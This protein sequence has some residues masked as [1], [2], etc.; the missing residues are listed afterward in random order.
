MNRRLYIYQRPPV[1]RSAATYFQPV[2]PV[3]V[4][5]L[6]YIH[7]YIHT[8]IHIYKYIRTYTYTYTHTYIHTHTN[9]HQQIEAVQRR[10]TT[11]IGKNSMDLA[12]RDRFIATNLLQLNYWLEYL[13]LVF[14]Y[15]FKSNI[16]CIDFDVYINI[17]SGRTRHASTGM[18]LRK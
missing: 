13:D 7:T 10:R 3:R 4:T 16:I 5:A 15:N 6:P 1:C 9:I 14:L 12:Y 17:C 2:R 11:F 18:F 8:Y